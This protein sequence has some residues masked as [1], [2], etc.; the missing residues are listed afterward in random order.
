MISSI[1]LFENINAVV[2]DVAT[3]TAD[4]IKA[5]LANGVSIFWVNGTLVVINGLRRLRPLPFLL[6]ASL[7]V[8]FNKTHLFSQN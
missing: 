4:G 8:P 2:P 6:V 5:F 7:V 3:D 1:S